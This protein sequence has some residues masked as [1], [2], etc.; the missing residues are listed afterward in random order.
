[1]V[2]LSSD[3]NPA[4]IQH[5]NSILVPMTNLSQNVLLWYLQR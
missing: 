2:Y 5:S 4:L 1:M 3:S